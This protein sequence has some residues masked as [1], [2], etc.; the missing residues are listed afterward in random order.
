MDWSA[1]IAFICVI[2]SPIIYGVC[3]TIYR[4]YTDTMKQWNYET[5]QWEIVK[6]RQKDANGK[7]VLLHDSDIRYLPPDIY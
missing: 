5:R 6:I 2:I 3:Y 1:I 7:W 4:E